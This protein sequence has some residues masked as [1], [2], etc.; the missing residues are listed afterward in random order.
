[1]M[2]NGSPSQNIRIVGIAGSLRKESLNRGLL[3]A[4]RD[5]APAGMDIE[6]HDLAGIPLYNG[7][8]E[9][10][11]VPASVGRLAEA[12]A[13]ADGV[14]FVTPEYNGSIPGVLKNSLDWLSRSSTGA[15]LRDKSVGIMGV[16]PGRFGTSRAQEHLKLLLLNLKARV[17][18]GAGLAVGQAADK[19]R[20]AE[21]VDE[22]TIEL[23][24][25]YLQRFEDWVGE[26]VEPSRLAEI[27]ATTKSTKA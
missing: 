8:I 24:G 4:A 27:L 3:Q 14:I 25:R 11:G 10:E 17:F 16:A 23:L 18:V 9:A 2:E 5:R 1:M 20:R 26:S 7:D 6:I 13:D 15:P 21:L 19:F 22:T 12:V